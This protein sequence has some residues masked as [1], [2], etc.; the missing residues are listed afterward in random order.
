MDD[1]LKKI[2]KRNESGE[3]EDG[4]SSKEGTE[5]KE[6]NSEQ[7]G[8]EKNKNSFVESLK[9]DNSTL[10]NIADAA[11]NYREK[12][13]LDENG[14]PTEGWKRP[15]GGYE[16]VRGEEDPRET[17]YKPGDEKLDKKDNNDKKP[18]NDGEN[19]DKE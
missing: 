19:N 9:V 15:E 5:N 18:P 11:K 1:I 13:H 6:Q 3:E 4:V 12:N 2:N 17:R 8:K 7:D 10:K 16:R 14:S